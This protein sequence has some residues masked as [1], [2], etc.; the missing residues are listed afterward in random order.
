MSPRTLA[1]TALTTVAA[2]VLAASAAYV[3][4]QERDLKRRIAERKQLFLEEAT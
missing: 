2:Y 4:Q 1:Y 3:W